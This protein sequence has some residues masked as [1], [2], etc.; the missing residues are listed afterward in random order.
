MCSI[1]MV[2]MMCRLCRSRSILK[3]NILI[4]LCQ[5]HIDTCRCSFVSLTTIYL[6]LLFVGLTA[7]SRLSIY[8]YILYVP[9][10]YTVH[11]SQHLE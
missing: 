10:I 1:P 4:L 11:G 8:Q 5:F 7:I 6:Y 9:V 2:C 3:Y